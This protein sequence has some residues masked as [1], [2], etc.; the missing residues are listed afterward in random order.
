MSWWWSGAIGAAK[1]KFDEDEA[2][3]S[4]QSV[5]LD[6]R[7]EIPRDTHPKL[8]ELIHRCWHINNMIAGKKKVKAKAKGMH[9]H[10]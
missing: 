2:P 8:V 7:P 1:K 3:Q 4:F 5:G 6:L 9:E 10:D